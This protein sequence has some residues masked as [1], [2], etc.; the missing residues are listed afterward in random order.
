MLHMQ[1]ATYLRTKAQFRWLLS[2]DNNPLL[3]ESPWLYAHAR[4][5]PSREDRET[6]G[7]HFWTLTKRLVRTRYTASGKTGKR[8]ADELLITT[9]PSST[10][11]V[12]HQ[13]RELPQAG[14]TKVDA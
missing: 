12:D 4:M 6:L 5:T 11:P 14:Q 3:T 9:L 13:L 1:L 10:V 2:Y 8:N 7:V